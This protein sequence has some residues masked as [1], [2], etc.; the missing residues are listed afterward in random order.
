M[1]ASGKRR[2]GDLARVARMS[3]PTLRPDPDTLRAAWRHHVRPG[4]VHEVRVL[5]SRANGPCRWRSGLTYSGYF[6]DVDA[7]VR[8]VTPVTGSDAPG[9]Y[10]TINPVSADMLARCANRL[11]IAGKGQ[12]T[13]DTHIP[14]L[15]R[16]PVD[17]DPVRDPYVSATD[18]ERAAALTRRDAIRAYLSDC[19]WPEPESVAESG[20][21]GHLIYLIDLPNDPKHVEIL[22]RVLAALDGLFSDDVV[23]VDRST[24]NPSRIFKIPGTVSAKGDHV[25]DRPHRIARATYNETTVVSEALLAAMAGPVAPPK[26]ERQLPKFTVTSSGRRWA[27]TDVLNDAGM[28]YREHTNDYATVYELD[29]C[30]TSA[31]HTDGAAILEFPSGALAYR[32][33]HDRC[34]DKAWRDVRDLLP[35]P[36]SGTASD[37]LSDTATPPLSERKLSFR[38]ARQIGASTPVVPAWICRGLVAPGSITEIDGKAKSAG[39]TTFVLAM[40]Q[41]AFAG[42]PFLN[43]PTRRVKAIYLT[44]QTPT[45]YREALRR[46]GLLASDD[47]TVLC[48]ADTRGTT[49]PV[50]VDAAVDA[51]IESGAELL[52]VDTLPQFAG[53]KGDAENNAG[54][55]LEAMEPLQ[56]AIGRGLAVVAIRHDRKGG[57][58]VGESGRGSSAYAGAVDIVL[59]LVR[60]DGFTR[61]TIRQLNGLSRFDETPTSL[62]FEQTDAG[63]VCHGSEAAV[64]TAETRTALLAALPDDVASARTAEELAVEI[65]AAVTAI[66]NMLR[67]LRNQG[68][69]AREGEGKKGSPYRWWTGEKLSDTVEDVVVS[70][71][72][73]EERKD[74]EGKKLSDEAQN[75]VCRKEK[76]PTHAEP[77]PS[78]RL[79]FGEPGFDRW[80]E[81]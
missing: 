30:L 76:P 36:K 79:A 25:P 59:Q 15:T 13:S 56:H 32:C 35:I 3:A 49:W 14:R 7:F 47:L 44:E 48:F 54:S 20:N 33:L 17:C 31:D 29:R 6:N 10:W 70:E 39:K 69:A 2:R 26:S 45:S 38:T 27:I 80:T 1:A 63:Y 8:A 43:L 77:I 66:K 22:R 53:L 72:N 51:A 78:M 62:V 11:D 55:A 65:D 64:K 52:I 67:A 41:A 9:I 75:L 61:P 73:P 68:F 81:G 40:L 23:T 58:N 57:G 21:G 60:P 19:G 12:L 24:C 4:D 5:K 28:V 37:K 71:N 16:L 18:E 46:A 42:A 74:T 34:T 50:V